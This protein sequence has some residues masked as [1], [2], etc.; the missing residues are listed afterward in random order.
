MGKTRDC[1]KKTRDIKRIFHAAVGII[2]DRNSK[3]LTEVEEIKK[4]LNDQCKKT[5][6]NNRMEKA[7]DQGNISCRN[8]HDKGQKR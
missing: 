4:A 7:R 5:E 2:K 1:F 3:D 6:E 8:G